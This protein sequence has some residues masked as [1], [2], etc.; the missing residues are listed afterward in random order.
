MYLKNII[1]LKR[2][3][4]LSTA[5]AFLLLASCSK[6]SS[7]EVKPVDP[8]KPDTETPTGV[9]TGVYSIASIAM[10]PGTNG[11][12][13]A[14]TFYYSLEENKEIPESQRSTSNWDIAFYSTYN[15]SISPN[16]GT[17]KNSLGYGGP[18]KGGISMVINSTI[19]ANYYD[20]AKHELK[21]VPARDLFDQA[22]NAVTTV[23]FTD[24]QLTANGSL[25]LDHFNTPDDG[26]AWYDFYGNLF[27]NAPGDSKQHVAYAMP[28]TII[29]KTAKGHYAKMIIY[30]LYKD[31]PVDPSRANQAGYLTFKYA[32]QK[33]G[34]K[35]LDIK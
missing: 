5:S 33:D 21:S 13:T 34:S 17:N 1:S 27:P 14:K 12:T 35:N 19:D 25:V 28:R 2:I 6:N 24:D 8:T 30:S 18:G 9:A 16:N 7:N 15:S 10:D 11:N 4:L 22:F 26:W 23:P 31:A 32:I 20:N 29:V 3:T